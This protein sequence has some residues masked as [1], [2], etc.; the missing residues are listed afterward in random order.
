MTPVPNPIIRTALDQTWDT[1]GR[2]VAQAERV[3]DITEEVHALVIDAV[4]REAL[5]NNTALIT[6]TS[7]GVS[8]VIRWLRQLA[9][10]QSSVIRLL[11][12]D[13]TDVEPIPPGADPTVKPSANVVALQEEVAALTARVAKLESD[14]A[15]HKAAKIGTAHK[16]V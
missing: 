8:D 15:A 9:Q 7:M 6:T 4:M 10:Q 2:L 14:L 11:V 1:T 16:A 3:E 12:P 13:L 5:A